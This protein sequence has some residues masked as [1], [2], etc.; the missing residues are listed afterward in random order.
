MAVVEK[1][2]VS[3]PPSMTTHDEHPFFTT[4]TIVTATTITSHGDN[5][6]AT[7]LQTHSSP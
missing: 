3:A 1:N 2:D 4:T 6:L 7:H 5:P